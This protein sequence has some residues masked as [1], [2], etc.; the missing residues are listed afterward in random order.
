MSWGD[1][2][3]TG[4]AQVSIQGPGGVSAQAAAD[5]SL[6]MSFPLGSP[7]IGTVTVATTPAAA[8]APDIITVKFEPAVP[9]LVTMTL[10]LAPA[11]DRSSVT[12]TFDDGSGFTWVPAQRASERF[13]IGNYQ[14]TIGWPTGRGRG[15][16]RLSL[17]V[18]FSSASRSPKPCRWPRPPRST[19]TPSIRA[20]FPAAG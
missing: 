16:S 3:P 15:R 13:T 18:R 17:A 9:G 6:S 5:L 4:R 1:G 10:T 14:V 11:S 12:V 20:S 19:S 2:V 7:A 8:T